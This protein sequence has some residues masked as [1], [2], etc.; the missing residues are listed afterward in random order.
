MAYLHSLGIVHRDLKPD[1]VLLNQ[2]DY[3]IVCDFGLSK[4]MERP[5]LRQTTAAGSPVYM[6]PELMKR[7]EYT[8]SI[9]VY[10]Y[11]YICFELLTETMA[12]NDVKDVITLVNLVCEDKRPQ[13]NGFSEAV[14]PKD[15]KRFISKAWSNNPDERPSFKS[16]L[17]YF[18]KGILRIQGVNEDKFK[19]FMLSI[20]KL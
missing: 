16:I 20:S 18:R 5:N 7:L 12:F 13:M 14:L 11:S 3:P 10:A 1:N 17:S 4:F 15:F 9:D 19:N 8:Y 2:N 6:A